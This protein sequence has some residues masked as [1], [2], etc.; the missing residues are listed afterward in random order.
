[1]EQLSLFEADKQTV[2]EEE[3]SVFGGIYKDKGVPN[4]EVIEWRKRL[5]MLYIRW[6]YSY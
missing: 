4:E 1:M 2:Y 5:Y 6:Y 3:R